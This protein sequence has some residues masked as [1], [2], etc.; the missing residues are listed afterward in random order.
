MHVLSQNAS[1]TLQQN[2][3]TDRPQAGKSRGQ[4]H[5]ATGHPY[6]FF[7]QLSAKSKLFSL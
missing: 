6:F 1:K 3:G 7:W 4:T 2:F 5:Q